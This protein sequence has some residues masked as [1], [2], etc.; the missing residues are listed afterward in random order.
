MTYSEKLRDP[1]WQRKRLQILERDGFR[2]LLCNYD[3]EQLQIHHKRYF[4]G[5]EPWEYDDQYLESLCA[6]CHFIKTYYKR[7]PF[8]IIKTDWN[9]TKY[10]RTI[11][12][13]C[14]TQQGILTYVLKINTQRK[15]VKEL[16]NI[17]VNIKKAS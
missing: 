7:E 9:T 16:S 1:R 4:R 17:P 12:A 6:T 2:C 5:Q 3:K 8:L 11:L 14:E 10:T 15:T 13:Y